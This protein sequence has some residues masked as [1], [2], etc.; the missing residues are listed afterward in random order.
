MQFALICR[1]KT[2][3]LDKCMA[4]R[5]AHMAGLKVEKNNGTMR[6]G[7]AILNG[8]NEMIGSVILCEFEDRAA[9]EDYLSRAICQIWHMG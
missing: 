4:G 6:D 8:N 9:L 5:S 7:E 2:D 1:D 3:A